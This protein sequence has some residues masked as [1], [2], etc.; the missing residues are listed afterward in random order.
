MGKNGAKKRLLLFGIFAVILGLAAGGFFL[1][2]PALVVTDASFDVLYG[3]RRS[4]VKAV[5]AAVKL[6][7][8]VIPVMIADNAG[9]DM[10]VFAV[11]SAWASPYCI[12]FPYRYN[13]GA[14]RYAENHPGVPVFVLGGRNHDPKTGGAVFVKTDVDT[15]LYRAGLCAGSIARN[16][17]GGEVLFFQNEV[18]SEEER[19]MFQAGLRE[20]G[21][22]KASKYLGISEEHTDNQNV[23]CAVMTGQAAQFL[24]QNLETPIILFSWADPELT[25]TS[26][27][28]IFDDSPWALAVRVVQLIPGKEPGKQIPS[29]VVV[30]GRRITEKGLLQHLK[31]V[32][33]SKQ[34]N[35]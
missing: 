1:R 24:D 17:G 20:A 26:V 22:E 27:K 31:N 25:A 33:H 29:E 16:G 10:V 15:D 34:P 3:L 2:A 21:I 4:R 11:E 35:I 30:L 6:Y 28:L 14:G 7:R 9:P 19:T 32:I 12:I 13:E 23:A 18:L 8:R 5:E